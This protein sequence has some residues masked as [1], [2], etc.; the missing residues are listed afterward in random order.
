MGLNLDNW[1]DESDRQNW[2]N[3]GGDKYDYED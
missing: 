1:R 3:D 2:Q